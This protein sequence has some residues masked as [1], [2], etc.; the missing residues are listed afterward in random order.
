[1]DKNYSREQ[2]E[3]KK[4]RFIAEHKEK[5]EA[6]KLIAFAAGSTQ[7]YPLFFRPNACSYLAVVNHFYS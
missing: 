5:D 1:M 3:K 4:N 6:A 7:A 2:N